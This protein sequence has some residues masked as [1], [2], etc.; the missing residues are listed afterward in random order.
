MAVLIEFAMFPTDKGKSVSEYVSRI[1]KQIKESGFDYQLTPMGTIVETETFQQA[2]KVVEQSYKVLEP[3]CDRVYSTVKFDIK[4]NQ[5]KMMK[6]KIKSIQDK[7]GDVN[8]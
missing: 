1:I 8:I 7:I 6:Q 4:K 3:D 2:L 5:D